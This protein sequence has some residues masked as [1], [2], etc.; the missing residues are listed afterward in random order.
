VSI[1]FKSNRKSGNGAIPSSIAVE[2]DEY[3]Q[4]AAIPVK[5]FDRGSF[6]AGMALSQIHRPD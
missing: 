4:P 3:A 6:R 5:H 1:L 2:N